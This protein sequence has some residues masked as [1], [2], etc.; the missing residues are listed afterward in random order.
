MNSAC[1][2]SELGRAVE[3]DF[4]E[5]R[6]QTFARLKH[7]TRLCGCKRRVLPSSAF[8]FES[9]EKGREFFARS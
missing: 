1:T 4:A 9:S 6:T 5:L 3:V 2:G 7:L 8:H